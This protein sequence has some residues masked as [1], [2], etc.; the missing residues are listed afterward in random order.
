MTIRRDGRTDA[1][2]DGALRGELV[3]RRCGECGRWYA[4]DAAGCAGCGAQRLEWA[5]A[6]GT[7]TLVSWAAGPGR[8]GGPAARIGLVELAE[9]PWLHA[10]LA[11]VDAPAEGLALRARFTPQEE[12]EPL[13]EFVP[14]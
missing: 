3:V 6:E 7:G 8:G 5:A 2:F 14:A 1:F 4:P 11:D 10:A 12:G 9:G 13:L